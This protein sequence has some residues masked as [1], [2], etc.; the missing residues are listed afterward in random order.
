MV[1]FVAVVTV[2]AGLFGVVTGS[3]MA[4]RTRRMLQFRSPGRLDPDSVPDWKV[5]VWRG[6]GAWVAFGSLLTVVVALTSG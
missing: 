1:Q 3:L 5:L 6:I 2:F 4:V